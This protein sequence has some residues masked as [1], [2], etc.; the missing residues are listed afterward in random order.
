[1]E[2]PI[3]PGPG[4]MLSAVALAAAFAFAAAGAPAPAQTSQHQTSQHQT[5]QQTAP[6]AGDAEAEAAQTRLLNLLAARGFAHY[7]SIL[8][9]GDIYLVEVMTPSFQVRTYALNR[10][11]GDIRLIH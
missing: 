6:P 9:I 1:M 3:M 4:V 7:Q 11:T 5:P 8:K 2:V 10:A